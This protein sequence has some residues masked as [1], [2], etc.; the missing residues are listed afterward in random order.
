MTVAL[1]PVR[2]PAGRTA[3]LLGRSPALRSPS[4]TSM[5]PRSSSTLRDDVTFWNGDALDRRRRGLQPAPNRRPG[6]RQ[7]LGRDVPA[8][9]LDREDRPFEVTLELTEPDA[10]LRN[11]L[12]GRAAPSSS[13]TPPRRP[14]RHSARPAVELMCTGP[15]EFVKWK[16]GD[17]I[18]VAAYEDYWNGDAQGRRHHVPFPG[19]HCH[20]DDG[21][22]VGRDR[23][24][25]R[26]TDLMP[27]SRCRSR[28]PA[29]STAEPAPSR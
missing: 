1:E 6:G 12:A 13:R 15:Y 3:G 10:Q 9:D 19:R 26:P 29:R 11:A 23:R 8:R 18:K 4:S 28:T 24:R 25:L 7:L 17:S 16:S 21:A 22:P 2:E 5:T 20:V 27:R 14:D